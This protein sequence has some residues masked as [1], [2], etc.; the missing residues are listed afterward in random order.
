M[1]NEA[2]KRI[3]L[4]FDENS[5]VEMK[6]AVSEGVITGYGQVG[7]RAVFAFF[8]DA[9]VKG[10]SVG[11]AHARKICSLYEMAMDAGA[12][13]VGY[14]DSSGLRL[15]ESYDGASAA[16]LIS[17]ASA[18]A[19]GI[20]PRISVIYGNAGGMLSL[21][22][23]LSDIRCM[24]DGASMYINSPDA[25]EGISR[26]E[27][28]T[29]S[30][31]YAFT[32]AGTADATGSAD[33]VAAYVRDIITH[34][35]SGHRDRP[36]RAEPSDD[37]NR[38]SDLESLRADIP[39][40]VREL[41]DGGFFVPFRDGYATS[42]TAGFISIGGITAGVFGNNAQGDTNGAYLTPPSINKA[43][44]LVKVCA[45][46][47]VPVISLINVR[48]YERTV[49]TEKC[50]PRAMRNLVGAYACA[51]IPKIALHIGNS[52]GSAYLNYGTHEAGC[53]LVY[54]W[55]DV[56]MALMDEKEAAMIADGISYEDGLNAALSRGI[57]DRVVNPADTRKYLISALD[58]LLGKPPFHHGRHGHGH[59]RC[60]I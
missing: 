42:L 14:L 18:R 57:V 54:A 8:Q 37:M 13:V 33:E 35:P 48:G 28:D 55:K 31:K 26:D 21:I 41:S 50:M 10:G 4:L 38:A 29:S 19:A 53:D 59:H 43:A 22:A 47:H 17:A 34:L 12:P 51:R 25:I 2:R 23:G 46:F 11:M 9:D 3:E 15:E 58:L 6:E 52:I 49:H 44:D 45:A 60:H 16:A 39:A 30:A 1:A 32:E 5:F 36:F 40:F 20:I 27:K 56:K 24:E 7:G